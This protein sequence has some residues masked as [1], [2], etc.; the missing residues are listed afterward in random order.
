MAPKYII[1]VLGDSQK[2]YLSALVASSSLKRA[3]S[4]GAE[5]IVAQ[6]PLSSNE[7]LKVDAA[8]QEELDNRSIKSQTPSENPMAEGTI[9]TQ[10]ESPESTKDS[11]ADEEK[12]P[13]GADDAEI[14]EGAEDAE[15]TEN[16]EK[17]G[18]YNIAI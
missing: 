2:S 18:K 5:S 6:L 14:T 9:Q 3:A 16:T 13:D 17:E 4:A 7:D 1:S 10:I 8:S 15:N 11:E 12:E